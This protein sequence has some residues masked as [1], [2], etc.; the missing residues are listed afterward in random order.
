MK[1]K[2]LVVLGIVVFVLLLLVGGCSVWAYFRFKATFIT[3]PAQVE[4]IAR[5]IFNYQLPCEP[6]TRVAM[7]IAGNKFA[8]FVCEPASGDKVSLGMFLVS[9]SGFNK[10]SQQQ[11][12]SAKQSYKAQSKG[13]FEPS[14]PPEIFSGKL[15]GVDVDI[16]VTKGE[17]NGVAKVQYE[18]TCTRGGNTYIVMVTGNKEETVQAVFNAL[19]FPGQPPAP[20]LAAGTVAVADTTTASTTPERPAPSASPAARDTAVAAPHGFTVCRTLALNPD[21]EISVRMGRTDYENYV[22]LVTREIAAIIDSHP[23]KGK[24]AEAVAQVALL[25]GGKNVVEVTSRPALD[26]AFRDALV[27]ALQSLPHPDV[28]QQAVGLQVVFTIGGAV[29]SLATADS[30]YLVRMRAAFQRR[31]PPAPLRPGVETTSS[32]VSY[33]PLWFVRR[34]D[35]KEIHDFTH[36]PRR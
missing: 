22:T 35:G 23:L 9:G 17:A 3:D 28:R 27:K 8:M 13:S 18:A 16:Q 24:G 31:Y 7:S 29:D 25:P 36:D 12:A 33:D 15:G 19:T 20:P 21:D 14:G 32:G 34:I 26:R 6:K 1:K 10:E 2:I 30:S 4:K 5:E 11:L